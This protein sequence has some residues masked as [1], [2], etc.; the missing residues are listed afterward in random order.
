MDILNILISD[1]GELWSLS[2]H[3]L[4][5]PPLLGPGALASVPRRGRRFYVRLQFLPTGAGLHLGEVPITRA[6]FER[7]VWLLVTFRVE[8]AIVE[9]PGERPE[10]ELLTSSEDIV[11]RLDE[12]RGAAPGEPPRAAFF[13]QRMALERLAEPRRQPMHRAWR[14]WARAR[15]RLSVAELERESGAVD[16]ERMLLRVRRGG[17]LET[18]AVSDVVRA[19]LPCERMGMLG[20]EVEEQPDPVYGEWLASA[21]RDLVHDERPGAGLQLVE[22]VVTCAGGR[23]VRTRYERLLLPWRS[24]GGDRWITSQPVLRMRHAVER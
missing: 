24:P 21:Y 22:A 1:T 7:L 3:E 23:A 18:N 11:A 5:R 12:L 9:Y 17:R 10:P 13:L 15:G 2:G 19:Y 20:R 4:P 14:E 8:R 16:S 6:C